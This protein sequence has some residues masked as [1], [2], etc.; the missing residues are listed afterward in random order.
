MNTP[1]CSK[2]L[3]MMPKGSTISAEEAGRRLVAGEWN[4]EPLTAYL[5]S[6]VAQ[7]PDRIAAVTVN[8]EGRTVEEITYRELNTRSLRF[9]GALQA[10]GVRPRDVVMVM[11]TNSADFLTVVY[12]ALRV[13]ATYSGIPITYG[14]HEVEQMTRRADAKA[15]VVSRHHGDRDVLTLAIPRS[16]VDDE[17]VDVIVAG[18]PLQGTV[19]V[20]ELLNSG[21]NWSPPAADP[22]AIAQ[23]AFTSGTTSAPKAVMNL[24][25]S[26]DV[27]V[28]GGARHVGV[29]AYGTPMVDLVM[30]P[31]G[32]STGFMWGALMPIHLAGTAVFME[33]WSPGVGARAIEEHRVSFFV[34]SPTF[35]IDLLRTDELTSSSTSSLSLVA[36]AGAPIPRPLMIEAVKALGCSVIPAWG[37][38]EF[39]IAV[40]GRPELGQ[41]NLDTDGIP[42]E[43]AQVSIRNSMGDELSNEQE[44]SLW[45]RGTGLFAGYLGA[46][47]VTSREF[48]GDWFSTGDTAVR[49][50]NGSVTITGRTKDIII[51]GG[52]NIPVGSVENL[53]F[54]HPYVVEVAVVGYPDERLGERACAFVRCR[55]GESLSLEE[56]NVFLIDLGLAK[57]YLPERMETVDALPKT[58]SGKIRKIDLREGL[59]A[60]KENYD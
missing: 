47:D 11:M 40:S 45:I 55:N 48:D 37:M 22:T 35:L 12:G 33:K 41:I 52:E 5:D 21:A 6:A 14:R 57:R 42:V 9:A 24:H 17:A 59:L 31:V 20:S 29:E 1:Q 34:G 15:L 46:E 2:P 38:T 3:P 58:M 23:L 28:R 56:L 36:V 30:S 44:G 26:L 8:A 39:G 18:E 19:A 7:F 43:S 25:A 60:P 53:V 49:S 27:V 10:R 16:I 51:R 32:H 13:G 4:T 50:D 54:R